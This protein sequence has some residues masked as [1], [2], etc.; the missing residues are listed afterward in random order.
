M[1]IYILPLFASAQP[2]VNKISF[3]FF[4]ASPKSQVDKIK[5]LAS[6]LAR[7]WHYQS[8][9]EKLSKYSTQLKGDGHFPMVT[10]F[11]SA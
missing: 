7:S 8:V 1:A 9:Y 11:A 10:S 3:H 4:F 6:S 2:W 5:H